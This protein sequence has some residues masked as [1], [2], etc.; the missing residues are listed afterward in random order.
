[1]TDTSQIPA[2]PSPP[3]NLAQE[4]VNEVKTIVVGVENV[5]H[6]IEVKVEAGWVWAEDEFTYLKDEANKAY[7]WVKAEDPQLAALVRQQFLVWEQDAANI[8]KAKIGP[9]GNLVTGELDTLGTSAANFAEGVLGQIGASG[10]S[11]AG[12]AALISTGET[13][14]LSATKTSFAKAVGVLI[15]GVA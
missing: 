3:P 4:A 1:M 8:A 6:G 11:K 5:L 12:V 14:L 13:M 15:A 2:A 10:A 7:N 9:L